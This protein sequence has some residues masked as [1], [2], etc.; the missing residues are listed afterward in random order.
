MRILKCKK[1]EWNTKSLVIHGIVIIAAIICG[2]VLFKLN[3]ISTYV[4][5]FT[6]TYIFYVFNFNNG[7]LFLSHFLT[8]LVYFYLIFLIAYFTKLKFLAC[9]IIFVRALFAVLY[10]IILFSFFGTDGVCVALI[11][12]IPSYLISLL[13]C[14][15][16][17]EQCNQFC[18]PYSYICPA[19]LA[20]IN[21]LILLI[22]VNLIFRIVV[23]IV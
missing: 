8:E 22:L 10:S 3:N 14:I 23:V 6:D 15:F 7:S 18:P 5:D 17:C 1:I 21:T 9:P 13:F 12:F 11:V 4:F 2:I 19:V 20:L 16:L